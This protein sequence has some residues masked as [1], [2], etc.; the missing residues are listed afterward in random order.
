MNEEQ[1]ELIKQS[2][3]IQIHE[4]TAS[5]KKEWEKALSPIYEDL[6]PTIG[7]QLVNDLKELKKKYQF[8]D[9]NK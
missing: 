5:Q 2:S 1:L 6:S 7:E 4:L 3:P 9:D 8:L